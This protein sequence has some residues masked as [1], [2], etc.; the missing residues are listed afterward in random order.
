MSAATDGFSAM[1]SCFAKVIGVRE[2]ERCRGGNALRLMQHAARTSDWQ[3][4]RRRRQ[5]RG[6]DTTEGSSALATIRLAEPECERLCA[7]RESAAGKSP[8]RFV[9]DQS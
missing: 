3:D 9:R 8:R 4:V 2:G 6:T 7:D 5:R 1:I